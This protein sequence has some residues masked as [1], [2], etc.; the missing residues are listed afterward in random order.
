MIF[1]EDVGNLSRKCA[2]T[3]PYSSVFPHH[4]SIDSRASR[5]SRVSGSQALGSRVIGTRDH[6]LP[7]VL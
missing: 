2:S 4:L 3:S 5:A 1:G 6:A 7:Y